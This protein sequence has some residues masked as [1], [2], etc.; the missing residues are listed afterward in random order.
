MRKF[1]NPLPVLAIFTLLV[2]G[3]LLIRVQVYALPYMCWEAQTDCRNYGSSPCTGG[4]IWPGGN[5]ELMDSGP[6]YYTLRCSCGCLIDGV[7]WVVCFDF[8]PI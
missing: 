8:E 6:F 5:C 2:I 1:K 4:G 3:V 7:Q